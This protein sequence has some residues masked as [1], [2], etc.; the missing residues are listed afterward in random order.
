MDGLR[1]LFHLI[2]TIHTVVSSGIILF[3]VFDGYQSGQAQILPSTTYR[4]THLYPVEQFVHE[5]YSFVFAYHLY[6]L[7]PIKYH[8]LTYWNT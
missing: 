5:F 1:F 6:Y 4:H 7:Q 2:A 3:T 8:V